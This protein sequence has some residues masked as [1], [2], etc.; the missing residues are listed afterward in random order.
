VLVTG[1]Q[2]QDNWFAHPDRRVSIVTIADWEQVYAPPSLRAYLCYALAELLLVFAAD[3]SE[4]MAMDYV[5]P[6]V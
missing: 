6:V 2:L 4:G 1:L 5:P 3:M